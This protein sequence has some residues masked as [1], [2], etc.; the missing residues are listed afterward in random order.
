MKTAI[1][2]TVQ[3][4]QCEA[5]GKEGTGGEKVPWQNWTALET[6]QEGRQGGSWLKVE[7]REGR[8]MTG[9]GQKSDQGKWHLG[10]IPVAAHT[11]QRGWQWDCGEHP[12]PARESH[13]EVDIG[14]TDSETHC[15]G[16]SY[17]TRT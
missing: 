9:P 8:G 15:S 1:R 13:C 17:S 14:Q 4:P 3:R 2:L 7:A 16:G 11:G 6:R 5:V 12:D 10:Q